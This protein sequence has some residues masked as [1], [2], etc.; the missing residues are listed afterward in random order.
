MTLVVPPQAAAVVPDSK[1]SLASV[2]PNGSSKWVCASMPPGTT[3][4]P[5]AS[6]TVSTLPARSW[7]SSVRAGREDGDD[8]LAVDEH[9]GRGCGRS[10]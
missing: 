9:V 3:Y 7:P 6:M 4:L 1:V 5:V 8:R 10:S 2:P